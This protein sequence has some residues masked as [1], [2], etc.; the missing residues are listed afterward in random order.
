MRIWHWFTYLL[1]VLV[2]LHRGAWQF[3]VDMATPGSSRST[4]CARRPPRTRAS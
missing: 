3:A 1:Y 2:E 4:A